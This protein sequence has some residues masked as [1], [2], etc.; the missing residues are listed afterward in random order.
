MPCT[1]EFADQPVRSAGEHR[2]HAITISRAG[3]HA[4]AMYDPLDLKIVHREIGGAAGVLVTTITH[5]CM[6][7]AALD[8]HGARQ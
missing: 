2:V 4:E 1:S 3:E 8:L 6:P 5:E 7:D